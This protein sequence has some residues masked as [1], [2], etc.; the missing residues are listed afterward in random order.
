MF[1]YLFEDK[2]F[3]KTLLHLAIPI[4]A[5][6]L[7][8]SSLNMVDTIMIGGLGEIEI[9]AVG[10]AN[11]LFFLFSLLL[12]GVNSGSAIFTAQFWGKRDVKNIRR[13]LGIGLMTSIIAAAFFTVLALIFPKQV[14]SIFS[15][16]IVVITVGSDYLR[17][18]GW[19]YVITAITF[20]FSSILRSTEQAKIPM[21][22]SIVALL[23]NTVLNY[24][25][26]FGKFGFP[27][28]GVKG[29]AIATVIARVLETVLM[30][31]FVYA[32][33]HVPAASINEMMDLSM[34]FVKNF[35]KTTIPV[36]L[37]ESLWALGMTVYA[38]V[39]GRIGT[40]AVAAVNIS[41][42]VEK[43][44]MVFFF[45][46][47]N[48]AAVMIGNRIG[49]GEEDKAYDYAKKL[50]TLGSLLAVVMGAILILSSGFIL[51]FFNISYEV[52]IAAQRILWIFALF[53]PI[54]MFNLI[55]IVGVL[56]SGGDTK[57]SLFLD[58]V[59]VWAIGIPLALFSGI[60]LGLPVYWVVLMVAA[61]EVFKIIF[62]FR[63]FTTRKWI[64]N[65]VHHMSN[66]NIVD[67][68]LEILAPPINETII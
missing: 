22:F 6:N 29:A 38:V 52:S 16:D 34:E 57:F 19:S 59:G 36:I 63:R 60:L 27:M 40:G 24:V 1:N 39:Y 55:N 15:S 3:Y 35:F 31:V 23:T 9:A 48:A 32:K 46:I 47:S 8:S 2:Q 51:T 4:A 18:V 25:L 58:V 10:Q 45:G 66:K 43:I 14:M 61:D 12:F 37:N 62:G 53:M 44:A 49:A 7:V 17:I 11:Q 5:Q 54:K 65:L 64:N 20:T 50:L 41:G 56:R 42:T 13:V 26:I 33:K 30:L 21:I 67:Q 68:S 28:L